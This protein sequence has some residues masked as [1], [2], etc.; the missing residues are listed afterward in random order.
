MHDGTWT[1]IKIISTKARDGMIISI[2]AGDGVII[3]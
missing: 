3:S 2:E 1:R